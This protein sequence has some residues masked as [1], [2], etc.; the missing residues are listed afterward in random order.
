MIDWRVRRRGDGKVV[1]IREMDIGEC[2]NFVKCVMFV[3]SVDCVGI[4]ILCRIH[5]F[6]SR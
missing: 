2:L 3:D 5:L 1:R 4:G 6:H